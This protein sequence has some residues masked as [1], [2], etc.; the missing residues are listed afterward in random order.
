M[1]S[2]TSESQGP[3]A[4][5]RRS[6]LYRTLIAAG[7]T[8]VE[9]GDAMV[10]A[11]YDEEPERE[12]TR[13]RNLGVADLSPLPRT[14]YKG[15]G[16]LEWLRSRGIA[17]GDEDNRAYPLAGDNLVA[18][19]APSEALL[20][21][22]RAGDG[23]LCLELD[24]AWSIDDGL[25]AFQ[26]PRRSTN[27]WFV[28]T[29]AYAGKMFAKICGVDLRLDKFANHRIAQ[30]SVARINA[31]VI[32]DDIGDLPAFHVLGDSASADYMWMCLVD[33][34]E[35]FDG[36]PVGYLTLQGTKNI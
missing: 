26:V 16:A 23:A 36:G 35:E 22:S 29:G 28:I 7:A 14:G 5:L 27:F 15:R 21:G 2:D 20:L 24:S 33:A 32:R 11:S 34:M 19:L 17:I 12:A 8:F 30:T 10:A 4:R 9:V 13:A 25:G 6:F 18:R 1:P 3:T 31:V